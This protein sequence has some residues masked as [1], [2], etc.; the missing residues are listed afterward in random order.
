MN[1]ADLLKLLLPP[2]SYDPNGPNLAAELVA[3][4]N[5]LDLV[6]AIAIQLLEEMFP[7]TTSALLPEWERSFGLPDACG[8]AVPTT[9]A[10]RRAALMA[11]VA[12]RGG[13]SKPY[14]IKLAAQLGFAITITEFRPFVVEQSKV[15][16]ALFNDTA[17]S[18]WMVHAPAVTV[19]EF[20]VDHATVE[21]PLRRWGNELLE[22]TF[23]RLKPP[24]TTVLFAYQS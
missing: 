24:H 11:K 2:V 5:A 18:T 12:N 19:S 22:C 16:D 17:R 1:H 9:L 14:F 20:A 7:N 6:M 15:G 21:E 3:E 23:R 8:G 10:G 4:G 13:L